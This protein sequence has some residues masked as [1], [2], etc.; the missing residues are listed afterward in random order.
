MML[1]KPQFAIW[2][3]PW[4]VIGGPVTDD[5]LAAE[6]WKT[7]SSFRN[8]LNQKVRY[9]SNGKLRDELQSL[10]RAFQVAIFLDPDIDPNQKVEFPNATQ[11]L[12]LTLEQVASRIDASIVLLGS[13]VYFCPGNKA[14]RYQAIRA[15]ADFQLA[16]LPDDVAKGFEKT[17]ELAWPALANPRD[18]TNV[19]LQNIGFT[20]ENASEIPFDL[21][22][23]QSL[24]RMSL[25][26]QLTLLLITRDCFYRIDPQRKQVTI[27][28]LLS[29]PE[30]TQQYRKSQAATIRKCI[31]V[32]KL[33]KLKTVERGNHV[34]V[35]GPLVDCEELAKALMPEYR[36]RLKTVKG[37]RDVFDLKTSAS[38]GQ[39]LATLAKNRNVQ[40]TYDPSLLTTLKTKIEID[41]K[42]ATVE[43]LLELTLKGTGLRFRLTDSQLLISR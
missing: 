10:S 33:E 32:K 25:F 24:P 20:L 22:H 27:I 31:A 16:R 12:G 13:M 8:A 43:E 19:L 34:Y 7:G 4:L 18:L 29:N 14:Y 3:V 6:N 5:A 1:C 15:A 37:S 35:R 38:R 23:A 21:W 28:N 17:S 42:Q 41:V 36:W 2:L 39:I 9:H 40:L 26:D 11:P 30:I